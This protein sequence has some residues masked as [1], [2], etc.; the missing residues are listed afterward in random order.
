MTSNP[1]VRLAG[2]SKSYPTTTGSSVVLDGVDLTIHVGEKVSLVGPSGSGK[3][4]LLSLIAGL[5][6]PDKGSVQIDGTALADLDDADRAHLRAHRIGIALQSDNLIPFLSARENV[7]LAMGFASDRQ[8]TNA[9]ADALLLVVRRDYHGDDGKR[10]LDIGR[11]C[12]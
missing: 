2:L 11:R 7:R 9:R 6:R 8:A 10:A 12:R 3:S 1:I 4:T 5:L